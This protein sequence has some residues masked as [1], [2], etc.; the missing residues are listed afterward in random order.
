MTPD[1]AGN[2]GKELPHP[3]WSLFILL[4]V[5]FV[6]K[7]IA[8]PI[9]EG[10]YTDGV[11]QARQ[12][13]HPVGIWPP[14]YSGLIYLLKWPLSLFF[15]NELLWSGRF[16]SAFFSALSIVPLFML[17]RRAFGTRAA[18]YA[19]V[20]FLTAPVAN[21]WGIRLMTDATFCFFFWWAAERLCV[22]SDEKEDRNAS[23][24][25]SLACIATVL[26]V[27]TRYQGAMLVPPILA[28]TVILYFR[29]RRVFWKPL[30]WLAGLGIIPLWDVLL[31]VKFIHGD[32]FVERSLGN[33]FWITV[34]IIAL[35]A[36]AFFLF[37]PYWLTYPV[38]ACSLT[39]MYWMRQRRGSFFGWFVVY[40]ALVLL[41]VQ[42]A[43][44]SFQERYLMPVMGFLWVLAGAGMYAIQERWFRPSKPW[45]KRLFP[46]LMIA[47]FT[48]SSLW[49]VAVWIFQRESWGD[50][51]RASRDVGTLI[52]PQA[53]I[54]TN[55][56]YR[57]SPT[58]RIAGDKVAFF[59][60]H[61]DVQFLGEQFV[62]TN[63]G[64]PSQRMPVGSYVVLASISPLPDSLLLPYLMTYHRLEELESSPYQASIVPLL[65]DN[66][67]VGGMIRFQNGE[68]R[69]IGFDQNPNAWFL[70]YDPVPS[71]TRVFVVRGH[72]N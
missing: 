72:R 68:E 9:N 71:Y 22:A 57:D 29:F 55:E 60:G 5:A 17:T 67:P 61:E 65:P 23:W 30:L 27:L 69:P 7:F 11:L 21:R 13:I 37:M 49:S 15:S 3:K 50:L 16:I 40:T 66:T 64:A 20:F 53:R 59:S 10:E 42:G 34:K 51:A 12:F 8:T 47:I 45:K 4:A 18:I 1:A 46:Y 35:N 2:F 36:E 24:A 70:R 14:L 28:C 25:L 31:G 58:M 54:F 43:F 33:N 6:L 26:A 62:N 19:G 63:G 38:A 48:Y 52:E 44:G 56:L 32:Q 39:G 41:V